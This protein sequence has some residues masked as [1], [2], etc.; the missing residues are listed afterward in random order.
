MFFTPDDLE[1][2]HRI[3]PQ[4]FYIWGH[5]YEYE[6]NW[7]ALRD[8]CALLSGKEEVWY[9]TNGEIIDYLSA[10]HA[11]RRSVDGRYIYNPTDTDVYIT[12]NFRQNIVLKKGELTVLE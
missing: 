4:L 12:V 1:R 2:P 8:Q 5:S 9:A 6:D 3:K 11:L 10:F 7:Q